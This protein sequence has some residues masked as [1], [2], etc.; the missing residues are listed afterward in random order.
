MS[1]DQDNNSNASNTKSTELTD[2][3]MEKVSGGVSDSRSYVAG[4]FSFMLDTQPVVVAKSG[5]LP[6][7]TPKP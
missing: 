1:T 4:H 6:G 7:L 2:I 5:P 3:E